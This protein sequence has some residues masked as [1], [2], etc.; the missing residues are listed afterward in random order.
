MCVAGCVLWVAAL[1]SMAGLQGPL[2]LSPA[3]QAELNAKQRP[4]AAAEAGAM[5]GAETT[6]CQPR[7][8]TPGSGGGRGMLI[9]R[10]RKQMRREAQSNQLEVRQ[11]HSHHSLSSVVIPID[12]THRRLFLA[13]PSC[14]ARGNF[15]RRL[16]RTCG[17]SRT[18]W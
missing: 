1:V 17:R 7:A 5:A 10:H 2:P 3:Q 11:L 12:R 9:Q 14:Q 4:L 13:L 18:S 16:K 6:A 15:R 8:R